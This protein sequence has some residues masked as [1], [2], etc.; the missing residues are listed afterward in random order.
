[1]PPMH[2]QRW[3]RELEEAASEQEVVYVARD[4]AAF[5]TRS[6]ISRLPEACRPG[7]IRDAAD[8]SSWASKRGRTPPL[9]SES[10]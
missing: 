10:C 5:L 8:I 1:M 6:E 4:Y 3:T 2:P 9:I 7:M